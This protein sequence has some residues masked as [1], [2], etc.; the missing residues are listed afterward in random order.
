[1]NMNMANNIYLNTS[2]MNPLSQGAKAGSTTS[3]PK[4]EQRYLGFAGAG[5]PEQSWTAIPQCPEFPDSLLLLSTVFPGC[6]AQIEHLYCWLW[7]VDRTLR[8]TWLQNINPWIGPQ[9]SRY[10]FMPHLGTI[11]RWFIDCSH[12][13]F[14]GEKW[15][16][17]PFLSPWKHVF[18]CIFS[19]EQQGF[20]PCFPMKQYGLTQIYHYVLANKWRPRLWLAMANSRHSNV[21]RHK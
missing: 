8:E 16:L 4:A 17:D 3:P 7:M 19:S 6:K 18:R 10:K 21:H 14:P 5:P 11:Y 13:W 15:R 2:A 12:R 9:M 1:M 20:S